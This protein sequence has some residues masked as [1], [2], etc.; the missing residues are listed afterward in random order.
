MVLQ[1]NLQKN[2]NNREKMKHLLPSIR[3]GIE[4]NPY[5]DIR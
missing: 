4:P 3:T 1:N 5:T 2:I